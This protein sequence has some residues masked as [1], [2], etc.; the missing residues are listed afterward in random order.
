MV[1]VQ[2]FPSKIRGLSENSEPEERRSAVLRELRNLETTYD[3][4][5][6]TYVE[7]LDEDISV[8]SKPPLWISMR[9]LIQSA[10]K[11]LIGAV[12]EMDLNQVKPEHGY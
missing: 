1:L 7:L 3:N 2:K 11:Q 9:A 5:F 12:E 8:L 4:G 10:L 6:K